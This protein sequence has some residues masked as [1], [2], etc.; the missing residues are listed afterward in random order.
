MTPEEKIAYAEGVSVAKPVESTTDELIGFV[1]TVL[2]TDR[3]KAV[4]GAET[5]HA[6]NAVY[7][8]RASGLGSAHR[9]AY[10]THFRR[11][12]ELHRLADSVTRFHSPEELLEAGPFDAI[13]LTQRGFTPAQLANGLHHDGLLYLVCGEAQR[14]FEA[15]LAHA[16]FIRIE[17]VGNDALTAVSP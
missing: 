5:A 4:I 16:G 10:C 11:D 8:W 13:L 1:K 7:V 2:E 15:V 17:R 12:D 14:E 3:V 9:V 6:I